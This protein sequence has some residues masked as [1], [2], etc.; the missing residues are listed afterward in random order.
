MNRFDGRS[1][2]HFIGG[3]PLSVVVY[4]KGDVA[5]NRDIA[6]VTKVP[7]RNGAS[8]RFLNFLGR[9]GGT[10]FDKDRVQVRCHI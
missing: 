9:R 5:I 2:G 1:D 6:A 10:G 7:I 4:I 3:S 8:D